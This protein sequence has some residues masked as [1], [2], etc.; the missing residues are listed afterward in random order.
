VG[1]LPEKA[2]LVELHRR[3]WMAGVVELTYPLLQPSVHRSSSVLE[4][5]E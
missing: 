1:V 3:D 4:R 5:V 2:P